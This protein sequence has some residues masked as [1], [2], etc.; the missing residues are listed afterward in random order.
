MQ[1]SQNKDLKYAT[2]SADQLIP[3]DQ[4]I[5][6][7]FNEVSSFKVDE[8]PMALSLAVQKRVRAAQARRQREFENLVEFKKPNKKMRL[9]GGI[10]QERRPTVTSNSGIA[11]QDLALSSPGV[12][13][14]ECCGITD[15]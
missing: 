14:D 5:F 6:R 1:F 3:K 13:N 9:L 8:S 12:R 15:Q 10:D 4:L 7:V 11:A 2:P